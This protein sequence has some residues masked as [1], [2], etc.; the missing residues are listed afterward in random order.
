MS[1]MSGA[2]IM[3]V[4]D[5]RSIGSICATNRVIAIIE[6]LQFTLGEGPCL[7]ACRDGRPVLEPDLLSPDNNRWVAFSPLAIEAGARAVFGFPI[8][9]GAVRLGALNLYRNRPGG[10]SDE[11]HADALVLA[12]IAAETILLLQA[13][14]APGELA[15]ELG[16]NANLRSV[17]HQA[18]G[19][20]AAQL[21]VAVDDALV[22]LRAS[23]FSSGHP[24]V[25]IAHSIVNRTLRFDPNGE[26]GVGVGVGE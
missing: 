8:R 1:G 6:E 24:V 25:D 12:D 10:L 4:T 26:V 15:T 21:G 14:A 9:V 23:A 18:S 17:V 22:R 19:M 20:A 7:E 5:G 2:S 16:A 13:C 3:L 11:Q